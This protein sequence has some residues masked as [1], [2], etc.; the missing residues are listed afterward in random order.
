MRDNDKRGKMRRD[1]GDTSEYGR[2]M[3]E[4]SKGVRGTSGGV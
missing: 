3:E 1:T 2:P 4:T